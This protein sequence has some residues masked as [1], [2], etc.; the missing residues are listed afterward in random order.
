MVVDY[1]TRHGDMAGG[2]DE[3]RVKRVLCLVD[4]SEYKRRLA[5]LGVR[6]TLLGF[7]RDRRYPITSGWRNG[8]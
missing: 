3:D 7:G 6:V 8:D 5:A 1:V 4:L 2:F